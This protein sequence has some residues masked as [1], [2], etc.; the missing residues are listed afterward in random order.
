MKKV[1]VYSSYG[2]SSYGYNIDNEKVPY[3]FLQANKWSRVNLTN[4]L[5][6]VSALSLSTAT[7]DV[8]DVLSALRSAGYKVEEPEKSFPKE[9]VTKIGESD[10]ALESPEQAKRFA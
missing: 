8:S 4:E 7:I 3:L 2:Y 1:Y 5:G 6:V 9:I 10:R